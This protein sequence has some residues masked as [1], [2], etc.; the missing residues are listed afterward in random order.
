MAVQHAHLSP[1]PWRWRQ[2]P[3]LLI[4]TR[5]WNQRRL[6]LL[7]CSLERFAFWRF[8]LNILFSLG[9]LLSFITLI[10][11]WRVILIGE[12]WHSKN[13]KIKWSFIF[14]SQVYHLAS[15]RLRDLCVKLNIKED[16]RQKWVRHTQLD[17]SLKSYYESYY[18]CSY[19]CS[20]VVFFKLIEY[21][22]FMSGSGRA[23]N[24][25]WWARQTWWKIVI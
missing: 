23:L 4:K 10:V 20:I 3:P 9:L 21:T 14:N 13:V 5:C 15:V 12:Q 19:L 17:P 2:L 16:L 8:L 25:L 7:H 22:F 6:D 24:I 18:E 11:L 1:V